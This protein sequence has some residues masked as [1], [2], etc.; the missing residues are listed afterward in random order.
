MLDLRDLAFSSP[1]AVHIRVHWF[2][3]TLSLDS[4]LLP[5]T[6]YRIRYTF[7]NSVC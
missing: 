5:M 1:F 3:P 6:I 7:S 2:D 4:P